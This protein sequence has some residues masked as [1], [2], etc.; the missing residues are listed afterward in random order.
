MG[1]RRSMTGSG[2]SV[3]AVAVVLVLAG[4]SS[5][6]GTAPAPH[7]TSAS[8]NRSASTS[9][10]AS[11]VPPSRSQSPTRTTATAP[12]PPSGA[13][14]PAA[15]TAG[16]DLDAAPD[17]AAL[18]PGWAWR[19]QTDD[20]EDGVVG[21]GQPAQARDPADV[22]SAL[23]WFDCIDPVDVPLPGP[24]AALEVTYK[25]D[26]T[27]ATGVGLVLRMRDPGDAERFAAGYAKAA[28]ACS[29][30]TLD[31]GLPGHHAQVTP[32]LPAAVIVHA[33]TGTGATWTEAVSSRGDRVRLLS[34][35]PAGAVT[36]D[37]LA[38]AVT[39]PAD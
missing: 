12:G 35:T 26:T 22:A 6:A 10:A 2:R 27:G 23:T 21:N 30:G 7:P 4:C 31:S 29:R 11:T 24:R 8:A 1:V 15:S 3:A 19:V 17:P 39:T 38:A 36:P 13:A 9:A 25:N 34:V 32:G 20:A 37:T 28:A 5:P 18:G 16:L 33:D 14:T